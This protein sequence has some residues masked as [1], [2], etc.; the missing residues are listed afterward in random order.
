MPSNV[1]VS[2]AYSHTE[3]R[4]FPFSVHIALFKHLHQVPKSYPD[5]KLLPMEYQYIHIDRYGSNIATQAAKYRDL[6]LAALQ[7]SPT[8][9]SSTYET[10]SRFSLDTWIA[11][12]S[13]PSKE[14]FV[15]AARST[16]EWVAQVTV[17][18]PITTSIYDL[19]E[20][21][22]QPPA[23]PDEEEEKWQMLGLY[24]LPEHRGHGIAKKICQE[25]FNYL[26]VQEGQPKKVRVRIMV[27]RQNVAPLKMYESMGFKSAGLCTLAEALIANGDSDMIPE[28][29]LPEAFTS[30][31][32]VVM[33]LE[34][35]KK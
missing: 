8:S 4:A 29:E 1:H 27:K 6:R 2:A 30:R 13:E 3:A 15:V 25:A 18:G 20:E 9:F 22:G 14:T 7:Q 16:G 28:G 34:L 24:T 19:P 17:L 21:S 11:R 33:T 23:L 31:G 5:V 32:G 35:D 10:E 26:E 12:L